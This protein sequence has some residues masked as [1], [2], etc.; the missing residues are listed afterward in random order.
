MSSKILHTT[1]RKL[2]GDQKLPITCNLAFVCY[3]PMPTIFEQ[4]IIDV[5]TTVDRYFIHT[6]NNHVKFCRYHD[7]TFVVVA[8]VY[9]GPVSVTTVEELNFYGIKTI[10][11]LGFVGSL[12]FDL[13]T[14][15]LI[16]A[17][18]L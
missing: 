5:D 15:S 4:Y 12:T 18:K 3:C 10:I 8:E 17:K 13:P 6:H 9:G 11:G 2:L 16:V 1:P 14:G 7:T